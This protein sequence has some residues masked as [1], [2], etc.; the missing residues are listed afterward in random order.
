[1]ALAATALVSVEEART[2][3]QVEP[4]D[5]PSDALL[6]Q[7]IEGLS[8]GITELT[9]KTYVNPVNAD[10]AAS[11][12]YVC[13]ADDRRVHIDNVR[14]ISKVEVT[15]TPQDNESWTE[16]ED[17]D[18]DW[19]AE[20]VG[21]PVQNL[22]RFLTSQELP[23]SGVGWGA[24]S[25]HVNSGAERDGMGTPWPRQD[26]ATATARVYVRVTGKFGLGGDTSAVPGNVRLAALMWLQNIHKRDQAFFSDTIGVASALTRMPPDVEAL[27]EG[28]T[29]EGG[30]V[31]AI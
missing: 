31:A 5:K 24:L 12:A 30:M 13:M 10:G 23:A 26:R 8:A 14:S 22:I 16:L 17:T 20:P 21:L 9:G 28:E 27:L 15:G 3:L 4:T 29:A 7:I 2:Y 11:R 18:G 6:E 19:V 25:L 1:M